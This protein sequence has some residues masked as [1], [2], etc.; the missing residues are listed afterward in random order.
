MVVSAGIVGIAGIAL[1]FV[2]GSVIS[3][4]ITHVINRISFG[5]EVS[6]RM[7]VLSVLLLMTLLF[8]TT[9]SAGLVPSY[10]ARKIDPKAFIS[11]E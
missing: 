5:W 11:Y 9:L 1:G 6:V 8:I 10:F 4:V 7:P 3:I 2:M